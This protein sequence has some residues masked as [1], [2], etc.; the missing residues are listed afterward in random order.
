MNLHVGGVL[1][2]PTNKT[3]FICEHQVYQNIW[4]PAKLSSIEGL[5]Y[6]NKAAVWH[7]NKQNF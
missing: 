7:E 4:S 3:R 2:E 6:E 5:N 1:N